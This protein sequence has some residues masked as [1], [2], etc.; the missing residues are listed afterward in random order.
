MRIVGAD[1]GHGLT[2]ILRDQGRLGQLGEGRQ[3]HTFRFQ[4]RDGAGTRLGVLDAGEKIQRT[5]I[6]ALP[7]GTHSRPRRVNL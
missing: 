2:H 7:H 6:C 5:G 3:P 4:Q 1:L